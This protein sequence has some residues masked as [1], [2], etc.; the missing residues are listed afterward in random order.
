MVSV[1]KVKE[2]RNLVYK[3]FYFLFHFLSIIQR[4]KD[5]FRNLI[6]WNTSSRVR[7]TG[8]GTNKFKLPT[9]ESNILK[10][11]QL[12]HPWKSNAWLKGLRRAFFRYCYEPISLYSKICIF[13]RRTRK[14]H[15]NYPNLVPDERSFF[16]P[17]PV[18][19]LLS[20]S[21]PVQRCR[22][23][24]ICSRITQHWGPLSIFLW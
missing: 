14:L 4:I 18:Q 23:V 12:Q 8:F 10:F 15:D 21:S 24:F 16:F 11:G 7:L 9:I 5:I 19:T 2:F 6:M 17:W 22:F 13:E 3:G 1:Q 20:R